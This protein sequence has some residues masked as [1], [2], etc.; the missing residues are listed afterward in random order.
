[1]L[2]ADAKTVNYFSQFSFI[3]IKLGSQCPRN[4][5]IGMFISTIKGSDV[6]NID[7]V[8]HSP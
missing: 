8:D 4:N 7:I 5:L 1:M 6:N 3:L 2:F